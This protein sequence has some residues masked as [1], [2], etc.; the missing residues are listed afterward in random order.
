MLFLRPLTEIRAGVQKKNNN[1]VS[2]TLGVLSI[3]FGVSWQANPAVHMQHDP[4]TSAHKNYEDLQPTT[5][6]LIKQCPRFRILVIGKSGVGCSTLINRVF[7]VETGVECSNLISSLLLTEAQHSVD[8]EDEL[9]SPQNDRLALHVFTPHE[10][11]D[12]VEAFIERRTCIPYIKDQ[13]HAVWCVAIPT[14]RARLFEEDTKRFLQISK[15]IPG[16]TPTIV[17]FTKS[18]QLVSHIGKRDSAAEQRYL[19]EYCKKPI[20]DLTGDWDISYVAVSSKPTYEQGFKELM[21]LTQRRVYESFTPPGHTVSAVPLALA[22]AQR[23]LPTSKAQLS[24]DVAKQRYWKALYAGANRRGFADCLGVIHVDIV[25][26]WNFYDPF[27][28]LNSKDFR[29]LMINMA[30]GVDAPASLPHQLSRSPTLD[31]VSPLLLFLLPVLLPISA[32]LHVGRWAYETYGR[33]QDVPMKF[34]AYIVD[35]THVLEILFLLTADMR[36]KKLTRTAIKLVY[37]AYYEPEW[38]VH[39]HTDIRSFECRST[40]RDAVLEKITSMI[41]SDGREAQVS[42]AIAS[43]R[44]SMPSVDLEKD[45][46]WLAWETSPLYICKKRNALYSR[47]HA[48]SSN[49]ITND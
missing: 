3:T 27:Q 26:V 11:Y 10:D 39:T 1:K 12:K 14:C 4:G 38:I 34:M 17:V 40:D 25:S 9:T 31:G 46:E 18:D 20:Q 35:L 22:D 44:E 16:N 32:A 49:I 23:M 42:G 45:E 48:N 6:G 36:A 33:L 29:H 13:L 5:E 15:K 37:K 21:D 2:L 41:S 19:Q 8:V 47:G 7:G 24:I 43:I 28:Y 30:E